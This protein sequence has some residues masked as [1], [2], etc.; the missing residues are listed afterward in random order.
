LLL[1]LEL[2]LMNLPVQELIQNPLVQILYWLKRGVLE[3]EVAPE[4]EALAVVV[5][6]V[7]V[8]L[9]AV[10]MFNDCLKPLVSEL[11]KP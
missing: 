2:L 7:E 6:Q 10:L 8:A 5:L 11:L 4:L 9:V 1:L 3:V